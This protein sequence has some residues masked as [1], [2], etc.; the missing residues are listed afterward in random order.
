MSEKNR[1]GR[2]LQKVGDAAFERDNFL[3]LHQKGLLAAFAAGATLIAAAMWAFIPGPYTTYCTIGLAVALVFLYRWISSAPSRA[4]KSWA[5]R[6]REGSAAPDGMLQFMDSLEKS[7]LDAQKREL[8]Y[9]LTMSKAGC[10]RRL[11]RYDEA[12]ALLQSFDKIWDR[13]Q[14]EEIDD[15]IKRIIA[16]KDGGQHRPTIK[17]IR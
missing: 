17:I 12:L 14:R 8:A 3:A 7:L 13:S 2:Q 5:I 4:L 10:L 16:E 6:V 15:W 11:R 9:P 1:D